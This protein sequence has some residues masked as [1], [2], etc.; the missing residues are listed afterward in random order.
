VYFKDKKYAL[1]IK[2]CDKALKLG[3][4][5]PPKLLKSLMPHRKGSK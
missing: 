3:F 2:H 5:V 4:N 1:A